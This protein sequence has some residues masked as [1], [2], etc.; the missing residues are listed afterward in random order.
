MKQ[1]EEKTGR[2]QHENQNERTMLNRLKFNGKKEKKTNRKHRRTTI[3]IA[4]HK[5]QTECR[6]K[7][8][9]NRAKA[10]IPPKK[11]TNKTKKNSSFRLTTEA[12]KNLLHMYNVMYICI[13]NIFNE[14]NDTRIQRKSLRRTKKKQICVCVHV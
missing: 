3:T 11:K 14:Q 1:R 2:S 8:T 13:Y 10:H 7:M 5:E 4:E 9:N 6:S 12:K